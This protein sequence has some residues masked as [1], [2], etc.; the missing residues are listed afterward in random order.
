ME[1]EFGISKLI[2]SVDENGWC[3]IVLKRNRE[4][5][6]LGAECWKFLYCKLHKCFS[7]ECLAVEPEWVLTLSEAHHSLYRCLTKQGLELR[8]HDRDGKLISS[9]IVKESSR[10][11]LIEIFRETKFI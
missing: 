9:D 11:T 10:L 3:M 4:K 7:E 8:W 1:I 5:I 6:F 2:F